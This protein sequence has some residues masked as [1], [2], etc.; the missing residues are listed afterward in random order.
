MGRDLGKRSTHV[1]LEHELQLL[2]R[3][4]QGGLVFRHP[5][6][7]DHAVEASL[8][9]NDGVQRRLH[10]R[11]LRHI[12]LHVFEV[13][14]LLLQR[15]KLLAGQHQVEGVDCPGRVR[16]AYFRDAQ[17]DAAVR[18]R[19]FG[20][21]GGFSACGARRLTPVMAMTLPA[22][23][24]WWLAL[25]AGWVERKDVAAAAWLSVP[26]V[27]LLFESIEGAI[28]EDRRCR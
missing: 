10:A 28:V 19:V 24:I 26:L 6:V 23:V 14:V 17:A 18:L 21:V 11:L 22:R 7:R 8:G 27:V 16:D 2:G 25:A 1:Q 3:E 9:V 12:D 4:V 15:E 13:G 20:K 5:R